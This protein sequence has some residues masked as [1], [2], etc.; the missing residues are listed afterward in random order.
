MGV[1]ATAAGLEVASV[2]ETGAEHPGVEL[3]EA[4]TAEG[5]MGELWAV[6]Q[7]AEEAARVAAVGATAVVGRTAEVAAMHSSHKPYSHGSPGCSYLCRSC[8]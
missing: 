4:G 3:M 8:H 5:R 6:A 7:R 2:V 1:E